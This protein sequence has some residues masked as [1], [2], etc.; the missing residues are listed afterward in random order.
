MDHQSGT[1]RVISYTTRLPTFRRPVGGGGNLSRG[2]TSFVGRR[3]DFL[4]VKHLL[5]G[6]N[7]VTL[8]GVGGVGKTR[9]AVHVADKVRST[10]PDG[11][12]L[13]E[14]EG[15]R[16]SDLVA[17]VVA[18][19]LGLRA[20]QAK[21]AFEV[22]A[23][24]LESRR[25][26]LVLDNCEHI[27]DAVAVLVS[28]LLSRCPGLKI[29]AT[30]REILDIRGESLMP[31]APLPVPTTDEA[32]AP[33]VR[34]RHSDAVTLFAD[35]AAAA[36]PGFTLTDDNWPIVAQICRELE[37]L[38]L[39][40]ELAA[41]RIS[42]L[43]LTQ[44][45][46]RL[47][48][49]FS[50]LTRGPRGVSARQQTLRAAVDWSYELCSPAEQQAWMNL[51]IFAGTFELDAAEAVLA[52]ES[53]SLGVLDVLASLI[54]KSI[55]I[56]VESS[57]AARFR[58]LDTILD[59]GNHKLDQHD[60]LAELRRRHTQ[61]YFNLAAHADTTWIGQHQGESINRLNR[62][63]P[64]VRQALE[65]VISDPNRD[66]A[67]FLS[68]VNSLFRFWLARGMV[69]EGQHWI[70]R[71]LDGLDGEGD[72]PVEYA[73]ALFIDSFWAELQGD[74]AEGRSIVEQLHN[75]DTRSRDPLIHARTNLAQGF[76]AL[77]TGDT[78]RGLSMLKESLD[79]F[80]TEGDL[81]TQVEILLVLGWTHA[82]LDDNHSALRNFEEVIT[83][84]E[85]NR[86]A[87]YRS[88]AYWGAGVALW[89][90]G[91]SKNSEQTLQHG[92][93]LARER[94]DPFIAALCM[95]SMAWVAGTHGDVTRAAI[96]MAAAET[97]V[98][99]AG[100]S[101]PLFPS[102]SD[103]HADCVRNVRQQLGDT[104][105]EAVH[106]QATSMS[107]ARAA[108]YALDE[109]VHDDIEAREITSPLTT[110]ERE[111]AERV[112]QG[113][114]NKTIA[115][116]LVISPRTAQGHVQHILTKLGFSR[117][118]QIAVWVSEQSPRRDQNGTKL[119][120]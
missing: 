67:M 115:S 10:F 94:N 78:A 7:L 102:M 119:S 109:P 63:L 57:H 19:E 33:G 32:Q 76:L 44:I 99:L 80:E 91:Q 59:Y 27:V 41:A 116:D 49:R 6:S 70:R 72:N 22:L 54:D 97:T 84:T 30:S 51:S 53:D 114:T 107:L 103:Y 18:G 13:V 43:S 40:I 42:S 113:L 45:A 106:R 48:D 17:E 62:E 21:S 105:F 79:T 29:V 39:A 77:F 112:A 38:P 74:I 118:A 60:Q 68:F 95:E 50:L 66:A 81:C 61:W 120:P 83:I 35:R 89:R 88:H 58:M 15:L 24:Y 85:A 104:E 90:I 11:V 92:V 87:V 5:G 96:L 4:E 86:E 34:R 26:L 37:G 82:S 12:W 31:V 23:E 1:D 52:Y 47:S 93:R 55:V 75:L 110:R 9:L 3:S 100:T 98:Q 73:R 111:V 16:D 36:L 64:N 65:F 20:Q 101:T 25:M 14:L 69:G 117:R 46:E 28:A 2:L 108:A 8:T 71:A 56:K